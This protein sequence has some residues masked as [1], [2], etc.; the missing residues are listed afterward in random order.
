MKEKT[1]SEKITYNERRQ[2]PAIIERIDSDSAP[3]L[4]NVFT[5][6]ESKLS[7]KQ[8]NAVKEICH[9]IGEVGL[10][11]DDASLRARISREELDTLTLHVPE[12]KTAIRLKQVEYKYKL[13]QVVT[14]QATESGDVKM[15]MWLLEKQFSEDFDSSVKSKLAQM[16]NN[17]GDDILEMAFSV[18]RKA[19]SQ[20]VP[21]NF[22]AGVASAS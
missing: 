6:L 4:A 21:V 14:R 9:A 18:V 13:L 17:T 16:G 20:T 10:S 5:T 22:M 15:A 12:I 8:L 7:P 1:A 11:L 2:L 19:S 3:S